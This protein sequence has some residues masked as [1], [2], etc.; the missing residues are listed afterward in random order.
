MYSLWDVR[1]SSFC[2]RRNANVLPA[3]VIAKAAGLSVSLLSES[4]ARFPPA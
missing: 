2:G 4:V 3:R 1:D